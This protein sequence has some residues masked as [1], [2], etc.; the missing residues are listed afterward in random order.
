MSGTK[1]GRVPD[2]RERI[3]YLLRIPTYKCEKAFILD[4][5]RAHVSGV[6]PPPGTNLC[7]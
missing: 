6:C 3:I 5:R 2:I 7:Q 4:H 1:G